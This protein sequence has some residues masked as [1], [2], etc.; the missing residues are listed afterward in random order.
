MSALVQLEQSG[1]RVDDDPAALDVDLGHQRLDEGH[2]RLAAAREPDDEQVLRGAAVDAG[3]LADLLTGDGQDAQPDQVLLVP[4][5]LLVLV[6]LDVGDEQ[7]PAQ[8]FGGRAAG[9][10]QRRPGRADEDNR[11][12]PLS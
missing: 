12:R 5:V 4:R 11:R 8:P 10:L 9:R 3:D 2:Q 1:R 6:L 7:R